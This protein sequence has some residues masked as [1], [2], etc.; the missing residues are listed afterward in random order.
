MSM[1]ESSDK[2]EAVLNT[3]LAEMEDYEEGD[4]LVEWVVVAYVANPDDTKNSAYPML[5]SNGEMPTHRVRGLLATAQTLF[6][7][8]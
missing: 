1:K 4:I 7:K 2:V 5:Y 8:E 6:D 3:V